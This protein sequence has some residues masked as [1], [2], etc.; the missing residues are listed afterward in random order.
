MPAPGRVSIR[1]IR[2]ADDP[3]FRKAFKLLRSA[4][5]RVEMLPMRDWRTAMRE[6]EAG[7]WTDLD[8]H[9][10]VAERGSTVLGAASGS[11][12]GNVNIG[13]I[14]YIALRPGDRSSGLG[15]R[16]RRR[17]RQQFERDALRITGRP[18]MAIVGE[19]TED[20]P[21]LRHLVRR[22]GAIALDF[23][24]FQPSRGTK[25]PA[26][27]LVLYYQPVQ[28]RRTFLGALELRRLLYTLWRRWYRVP[29]PLRKPEFRKMLK[30]L[31]GR[32]RVGQRELGAERG[33]KRS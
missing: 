27:P 26:I 6:R 3:A 10:L 19:V 20:N 24:Y 16:L 22:E 14:G 18:L 5:T 28:R 4:F 7:L 31:E 8:W 29:D 25:R 30:S 33:A 23:P 1:E 13:V 12:L 32:R 2:S 17:L 15:P 21:W 9:L 11:Y